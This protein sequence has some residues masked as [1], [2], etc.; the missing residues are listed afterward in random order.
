M[1]WNW[2]QPDW[3]DFRWNSDA[4]AALEARDAEA[5]RVA[6]R[7]HLR[8]LIRYLEPLERDRPD[9]FDPA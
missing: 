9:L 7:L 4:L 3:P 5:A 1:K 2:Q 8:Q 6:V